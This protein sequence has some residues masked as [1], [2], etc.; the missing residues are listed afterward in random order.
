MTFF[1]GINHSV[2]MMNEKNLYEC[3]DITDWFADHAIKISRKLLDKDGMTQV[4]QIENTR[5]FH[6]S[7][8]WIVLQCLSPW[9]KPICLTGV[10]YKNVP[11]VMTDLS[12]MIFGKGSFAR[13]LLKASTHA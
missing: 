9:Q 1:S 11:L 13:L 2:A 10:A 5:E 3:F 4:F 6:V 8:Q 12:G 7:K